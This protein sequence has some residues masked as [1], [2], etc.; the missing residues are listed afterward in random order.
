MKTYFIIERKQARNLILRGEQLYCKT[1]VM[2]HNSLS[3]SPRSAKRFASQEA[4]EKYANKW[5][6]DFIDEISVLRY[7][8]Y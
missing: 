4:A 3:I 5:F 8:I 6:K 1:Y 7:V 2:T